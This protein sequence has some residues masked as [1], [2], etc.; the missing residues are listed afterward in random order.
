MKPGGLISRVGCPLIVHVVHV[1]VLLLPTFML[2]GPLGIEWA[3]GFFACVITAAALLESS[4]VPRQR[5]VR[6][7]MIRDKQALRVARFVGLYLLAVFWFAQIER[8]LHGRSVPAMQIVGALFVVVG[9]A[10][11]VGAIRTLGAQFVSDIQIG[12]PIVRDGIYAWLR[13]PSEIGLLLIAIG[14]PL[15]ISSPL[16]AIAAAT[17]L[18]PIS[19]WRM[20]RESTALAGSIRVPVGYL[21]P[22]GRP[23]VSVTPEPFSVG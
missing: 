12:G 19:L 23:A 10:L 1:L 13:H 15:L 9:I 18:L 8:H 3:T 22:L 16:T 4:F 6:N 7:A 14:A 5:G 2:A 11:R 17:V 21:F 20:R